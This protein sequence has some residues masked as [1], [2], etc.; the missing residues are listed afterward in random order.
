MANELTNPVA[1]VHEAD[2]LINQAYMTL[3]NDFKE[4]RVK[5][6]RERSINIIELFNNEIPVNN[7]ML[8]CSNAF[9]SIVDLEHGKGWPAVGI[10]TENLEQLMGSLPELIRYTRSDSE[11][12]P[13][14]C[15]DKVLSVQ[16]DLVKALDNLRLVVQHHRF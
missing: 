7:Q 6:E 14:L 2:K 3:F 15:R 12:A 13:R 5:T 11:T 1:S 8:A 4:H 9:P 16:G 10:A